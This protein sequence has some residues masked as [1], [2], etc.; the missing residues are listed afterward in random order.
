MT[1]AEHHGQLLGLSKPWRVAEVRLDIAGR[2]VEIRLVR[3]EGVGLPCPE[4]GRDC[5]V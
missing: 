3:D 1:L 2:L 5:P 4:C